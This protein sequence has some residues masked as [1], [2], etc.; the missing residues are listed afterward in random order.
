M[1]CLMMRVIFKEHQNENDNINL[2]LIV[3]F[4]VDEPLRIS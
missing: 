3:K 4:K 1:I 2:V